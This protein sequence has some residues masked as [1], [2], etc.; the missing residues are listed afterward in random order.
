MTARPRTALVV[1]GASGIGRATV[2]LLVDD[3]HDVVVLGLPGAHLEGLRE[4]P[5]VVTVAG[6][7]SDPAAAARAVNA[8][9]AATGR[10]D[11]VVCCAGTGTF[12]TLADAG[13]DDWSRMVD[14]NLMTAVHPVRAALPHL[15][16]CRGTVVLVSSLAGTLAVPGS[17]TYTVTKH[18][19]LGLAR[20][21]A[22]DYGPQGVRANVVCPGPVATEMFDHVMARAAKLLSIDKAT[23]YDRAA[24]L[25]PR[26]QVATPAEIADV[27]AFLSGPRSAAVNGAVLMADGGVSAADVS[28]AALQ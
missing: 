26:R 1:G 23:A 11:T 8:A 27:I 6:D 16:E 12:G 20:S 5:G 19:L 28:M 13:P 7:A 21:I 18:A 17:A 4:L 25:N 14:A 15:V 9:I 10:L 24:A 2:E 3:A 22:T